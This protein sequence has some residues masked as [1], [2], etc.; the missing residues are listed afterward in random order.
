MKNA[1]IADILYLTHTFRPL[2][3]LCPP[4]RL[5]RGNTCLHG[6][7]ILK[8]SNL[9]GLFLFPPWISSVA[10]FAF[11]ENFIVAVECSTY[12]VCLKIFSQLA[13][14]RYSLLSHLGTRA[15]IPPLRATR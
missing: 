8:S 13:A 9:I 2:Q 6:S 5:N 12:L 3:L 10:W 15:S 14:T 1:V 7:K 11:V 4:A